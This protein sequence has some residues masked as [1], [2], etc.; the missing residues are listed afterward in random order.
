MTYDYRTLT[1]R[2]EQ[3]RV[4]TSNTCNGSNID[5]AACKVN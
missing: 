3:M 2:I 5:N 4:A 1:R